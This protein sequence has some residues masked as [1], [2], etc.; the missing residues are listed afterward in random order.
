VEC[1]LK[2]VPTFLQNA[3]NEDI[4]LLHYCCRTALCA[5][6]EVMLRHRKQIQRCVWDITLCSPWKISRHFWGTAHLHVQGQRISK[7][8]NQ[9][10]SRSQAGLCF[11]AGFL[12]GLFFDPEDGGDMFLQNVS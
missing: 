9:H 8:R 12:F 7:A 2:F 11:H 5:S 1:F 4:L 10:E 3:S 6:K